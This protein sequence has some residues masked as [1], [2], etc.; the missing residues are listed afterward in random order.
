MRNNSIFAGVCLPDEIMKEFQA[1][2]E[3]EEVLLKNGFNETSH[4]SDRIKGKKRFKL[5][6]RGRKEIYFDYV[7]IHIQS[8]HSRH[9]SRIT[10]NEKELRLMLLFF[11]LGTKDIEEV[12]FDGCY[13][14]DEAAARYQALQEELDFHTKY[15][16]R[17]GRKKVIE[18]IINTYNSITI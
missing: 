17:R 15:T 4:E 13:K 11:K 14:I 12:I 3:L 1:N 6:Q 16:M 10:L 9:D 18:R 8:T 2:A 5:T 7:N